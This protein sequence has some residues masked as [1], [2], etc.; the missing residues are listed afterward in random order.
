MIVGRDAF[1]LGFGAVF[2]L[3][4]L[5][6]PFPFAFRLFIGVLFL[7]FG[8]VMALLRVGP[9]KIP[10]EQW[11]I[12]WVR[13]MRSQRRYTY[14]DNPVF[15]TPSQRPEPPKAAPNLNVPYEP[16]SYPT[17]GTQ[18]VPHRDSLSWSPMSFAWDEVGYYPVISVLLGVLGAYLVYW[19]YSFG[20]AEIASIIAR[21]R[22]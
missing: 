5:F 16:Q 22:R 19:L 12:R 21:V 20:A 9:D 18:P 13:Y 4:A 3:A 6:V 11:L 14:Q 2:A 8:M 1:W 17:E 10:V 7:A 15:N